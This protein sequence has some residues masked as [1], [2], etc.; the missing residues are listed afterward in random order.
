HLMDAGTVPFRSDVSIEKVIL[1]IRDLKTRRVADIMVCDEDDR[2]LGVVPVFDLLG[3]KPE[4][5]LGSLLNRDAL[6]VHA[7]TSGDEVVEM[8]D[9]HRL[10]SLPVV[11][12]DMRLLGVIRHDAFVRAA[13]KAAGDDLGKMVG[14]GSEERALSSAAF[15]VKSR[16]PWLLINL[17]TAFAAASVVGVFDET[18]ARFTAL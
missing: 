16:L 12:L 5:P 14:V 7:M 1:G 10:A 2:L 13:Q 11:D 4:A 9:Q 17:V 6:F 18:I 15:T 8:L 3:A